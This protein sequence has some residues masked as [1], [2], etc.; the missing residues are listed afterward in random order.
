MLTPYAEERNGVQQS[1]KSCTEKKKKIKC[2]INFIFNSHAV[3][4]VMGKKYCRAGQATN[5][6][7]VHCM[8][9]T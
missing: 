1:G 8:V 4:N 9:D 7:M 5:A 3:Y 6:N 2:S